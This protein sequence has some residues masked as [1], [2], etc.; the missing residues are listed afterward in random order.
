VRNLGCQE[1]PPN[2]KETRVSTVGKVRVGYRRTAFCRTQT[3]KVLAR[4]H[5][6]RP[7][8]EHELVEVPENSR[9]GAVLE[10]LGTGEIDLHVR[11]AR[12]VPLDPGQGIVLAA[13]TER[14][15]PFDVLVSED[16]NLLEDLE[17]G[18]VLAVESAR[19]A[20]QL[21][22]FRDDLEISRV[23]G[24][25]DRLLELLER[26]RAAAFVVAAEDVEMLGWENIV[27]EVF[28]PDIVL[29]AAG[30]GSFALLTREGNDA[31]AELAQA[32][33]HEITR[34][35]ILAERAFLRELEVKTTDPVAVHGQV[36]GDQVVLEGL[37][38]DAVSGAILR[39]ELDG[40]PE[41]GGDLGVRLAKLFV[42][43]GARDYI[44]G[45]E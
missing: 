35:I 19:V 17:E 29:P 45:Y 5:E 2:P 26:K 27:A 8:F 41:E 11:G 40:E 39:D 37:L 9:P 13:C 34:Q 24:T 44:A 31:A 4:L 30:Q 1:H 10:A 20:V 7:D 23:E 12:E 6:V 43:D 14:N 38:G 33:D 3:E 28:P 21:G 18:A 16:G 15:D 22:V 32:L 25:V 36:E 42:A